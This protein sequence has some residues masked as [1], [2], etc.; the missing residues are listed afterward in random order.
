[1]SKAKTAKSPKRSQKNKILEEDQLDEIME[2]IT[3]KRPRNAYTQFCMEEVEKFK[4]KNK[5]KKINLKTFSGECAEKWG[6]LSEK[7]KAKYHDRFEEEKLTYK[8]DLDTVRHYIFMDYNDI[9]HRPP[10]AYRLY[11]NEKLREGF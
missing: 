1:M 10:T 11:L 7:E 8:K 3:L 9:V 4:N 6:K 2:N 5:S